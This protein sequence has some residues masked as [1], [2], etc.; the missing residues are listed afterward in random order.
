MV[1]GHKFDSAKT[2]Q[3]NL[4]VITEMAAFLNILFELD[5]LMDYALGKALEAI[6][7]ERGVLLLFDAK[8][9]RLYPGAFRAAF[10]ERSEEIRLKGISHSIT[11][12][13]ITERVSILVENAKD[14]SRFS[15]ASSVAAYNLRS[16]LAV[17]L[18]RD[19]VVRG[20]IYLDNR[21]SANAFGSG[22]VDLATA[23]AN[24]IATGMSQL[25]LRVR[26]SL[27]DNAPPAG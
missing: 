1:S 22:H 15:S 23:L 6:P 9:R 4:R 10:P 12:R 25:E 3:T 21:T 20:L 16:V 19:S 24:L 13:A 5:E 18:W 26:A 17:P 11:R 14:D 27:A 8:L 2:S 7:A